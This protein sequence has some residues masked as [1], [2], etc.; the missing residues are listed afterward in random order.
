MKALTRTLMGAVGTA[1]LASVSVPAMARIIAQDD[2]SVPPY[3]L[4][5]LNGKA[6]GGTGFTGSW[7]RVPGLEQELSVV[8]NGAIGGPSVT[9]G[10]DGDYANFASPSSL[11]TGQLFISYTMDNVGGTSLS[12]T[13][14][15]LNLD[16]PPVASDRAVLGG[17]QPGG[18]FGLGLEGALGSALAQSSIST[19]GTHKVV[20]VLDATNDQIAIFV[21]PTAGSFYD[22]NGANDGD[23]VAAWTPSGVL[24]FSSY[25]L[26]ENLNDQV[27]FGD[28]VFSTDAASAGISVPEP[29]SM[30][31]LGL[32]LLGLG[33]N[34]RRNAA[35]P[36][37]AWF[38]RGRLPVE[39][40]VA[41]WSCTHW[42][43]TPGV[44]GGARTC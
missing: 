2:F 43:N 3:A 12:T 1:A 13:R 30:A 9:A 42:A 34:R 19:T 7:A 44:R 31:L 25:S 38:R 14:L 6:V 17:F 11:T 22:A 10:N 37:R 28:V 8:A 24:T 39:P 5:P 16:T 36:G 4:G 35:Q 21:D 18:D 29:A 23:A 40:P 32:G 20:G 41:R 27:N 33:L 26:I 15:D